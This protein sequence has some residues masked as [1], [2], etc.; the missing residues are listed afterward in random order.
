VPAGYVYL[1]QQYY[2]WNDIECGTTAAMPLAALTTKC[3]A[4]ATCIAIAIMGDA[5]QSVGRPAIPTWPSSAFLLYDVPTDVD[6]SSSIHG[7]L[8]LSAFLPPREQHRSAIHRPCSF[9]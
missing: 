3:N 9:R 1:A 5:A 4:D 8:S 7:L 6:L 2:G